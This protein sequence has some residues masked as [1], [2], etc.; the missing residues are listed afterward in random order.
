MSEKKKI[1]VYL[2][3]SA[4]VLCWFA[5]QKDHSTQPVQ[6]TPYEQWKSFN[7]HDYTIHQTRRCFCVYGSLMMKIAVQSDSISSVVN[8]SDSNTIL[9]SSFSWYLTIDSLFRII[10][11]A[12]KTDSMVVVYNSQ[13]GYP[14]KLDLNP[15]LHPVDGGIL[16]ETSNLEIP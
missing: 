2:L 1:L 12:N 10:Q 13:Y 8:L 4:L 14:E 9:P 6:S 3:F 11:N 16:Y 7:M 15:Q 5:C